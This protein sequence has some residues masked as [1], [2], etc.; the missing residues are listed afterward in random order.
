MGVQS[1]YLGE[2]EKLVETV[3]VALKLT[4]VHVVLVLRGKISKKK[5]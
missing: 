3:F 5:A 2:K 4:T 1:P